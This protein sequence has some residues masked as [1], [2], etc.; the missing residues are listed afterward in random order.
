MGLMSVSQLVFS[1]KVWTLEECINRAFSNNLSIKQRALSLS[2]ARADHV[3]SKMSLLPSLNAQATH[4]LNT[5]FSINPVTNQ[6]VSDATFRSN[7]FGISGSMNLFNGFQSMNNIRLQESNT[8]A[9][10][11]DFKTARNTIA[12]TVA[13]A[14]MNVLLNEE[15]MKAR[16]L[17]IESTREQFVR[18]EK[19]FELGGSNKVKVLQ[20]KAQLANEELQLVMAQNQ[21]SQAYLTL[22]QSINIAPDTTNKIFKP[23]SSSFKIEEEART[24]DM[25][26]DD[27]KSRSPEM[28]AARMRQRSSQLSYYIAQGTRS[29]RLT[30]NAGINSF[31]TTQNLLPSGQPTLSSSIIGF[32]QA[33]NPV[34]SV[35]MPRYS[36]TEVVP[37]NTQFDRNLGK[38]LGLTLSIPVFNGWQ[39]NTNIQKARINQEMAMVNEEQVSLDVYKN[40]YQSYLD[41]KTAQKQMESSENNYEANKE[42]YELAS[43]QLTLGAISTNDYLTIKNQ[44]LSAETSLLQAR[45]Q[46][47]F[48][49]KVLDFYSGK[50]LY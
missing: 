32:D 10:E 1:Q 47:I 7:N 24:A 37:F 19:L 21:L 28:Q 20:L 11:E 17:Q 41:F 50:S 26:F 3:Q 34:M 43:G 22:W 44:Y 33:G 8:R 15:I 12:L 35:P 6:T 38:S 5:G 9:S 36:S 42:A 2:T 14:Y 25:I 39:A 16:Q 30:L 48:R 46:L 13:N 27:F 49:R 29:P 23:D 4:N 40:V 31:Y 18:Q 45:Y